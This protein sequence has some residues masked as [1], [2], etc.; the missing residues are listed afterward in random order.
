MKRT[1]HYLLLFT[2][3]AGFAGGFG[4][5]SRGAHSAASAAAPGQ[6]PAE[7]KQAALPELPREPLPVST[8]T[9]ESL[10][11]L[12]QDSLY[13]RLALWLLDAS[14]ADI[15]AFWNAWLPK[16]DAQPGI[17]RLIFSQWAKRNPRGMLEAAKLAG[18]ESAAWSAWASSDPQ[19]A[20]AAV[21]SPGPMRTAVLQSLAVNEPAQALK[22]LE[23]DASLAD[24]FVYL[25]DI[26]KAA[27]P[28]DP[29]AQ[30]EF[31]N[32]FDRFQAADVFKA[33]A[34]DDPHKALGWLNERASR[35]LREAYLEIVNQANPDMLAEL[36]RESA[37][38]KM[39]RMLEEAAFTRLATLDPAKALEE[40]RKTEAPKLAAERM[41]QLGRTMVAEKPEQALEILAEL[42]GKY[43]DAHS[44]LA[45]T[46]YPNGSQYQQ[47]GIAGLREFL[48]ALVTKDP[49]QTLESVL[50]IEKALPG[51]SE[52]SKE[53]NLDPGSV[54]VARF[55]AERDQEAFRQ[56]TEAQSDPAALEAAARVM[57][58][59]LAQKMD[60]ASAIEWAGRITDSS[61]RVSAIYQAF[62]GWAIADPEAAKQ[63]LGTA[64]LDQGTKNSLQATFPKKP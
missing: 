63:W 53:F 25:V 52:Q 1:P 39:K 46:R 30:I 21:G 9:C 18:K 49:R 20:L 42:F 28:D 40:A 47:A 59:Q 38:G 44:R 31:L 26:A 4:F 45:I 62:P 33:W 24:V 64:E 12:P 7:E 60:F 19:A 15:V 37:P 22:M 6:S 35:Q 51:P 41:A 10:L 13:P 50:G 11:Q 34:K 57:A 43:P 14:E 17:A 29:R 36:A 5:A 8:D 2:A 54:T 3:V 16:A 55:W 58:G 61:K 32:R 27:H 56:W 23:A 48:D